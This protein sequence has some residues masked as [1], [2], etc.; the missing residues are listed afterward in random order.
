MPVM[1]TKGPLYPSV[2]PEITTVRKSAKL[3]SIYGRV[4]AQLRNLYEIYI[5][6]FKLYLV[7][8]MVGRI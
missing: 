2:V 6:I 7:L 3:V 1:W 8:N 5:Y 4:L